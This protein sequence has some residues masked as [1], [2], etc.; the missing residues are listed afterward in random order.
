MFTN[1]SK[2]FLQKENKLRLLY[3]LVVNDHQVIV[4]DVIKDCLVNK[5][6]KNFRENI[7]DSKV[8]GGTNLRINSLKK[9]IW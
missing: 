9:R 7:C 4:D 2:A 3:L 1:I 8:S 6:E 5:N